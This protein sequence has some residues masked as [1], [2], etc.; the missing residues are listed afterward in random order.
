MLIGYMNTVQSKRPEK[1]LENPPSQIVNPI[2]DPIN[3][4]NMREWKKYEDSRKNLQETL[5][6]SPKVWYTIYVTG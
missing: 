5:D 1:D 6:K 4:H 3:E 2:P